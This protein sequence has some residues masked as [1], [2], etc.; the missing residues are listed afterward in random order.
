[1]GASRLTLQHHLN[2]KWRFRASQQGPNV[3]NCG[4][5]HLPRGE[6]LPRAPG[7]LFCYNTAHFLACLGWSPDFQESEPSWGWRWGREAGLD[8][9]PSPEELFFLF[10]SSWFF[11]VQESVNHLFTACQEKQQP[12]CDSCWKGKQLSWE[13]TQYNALQTWCL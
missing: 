5:V 8:G 13:R 1:M 11:L 4:P 3:T 2:Q 10:V 6:G 12:K 7:N 9:C